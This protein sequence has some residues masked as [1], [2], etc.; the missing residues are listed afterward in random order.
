MGIAF[1]NS[2]D[3][4]QAAALMLK[5]IAFGMGLIVVAWLASR[6][7]FDLFPVHDF[8]KA[9]PSMFLIRVSAVSI[10]HK[11]GVSGGTV[12]RVDAKDS[13]DHR[14][15]ALVHLYP[16][17]HHRLR[18]C[19]QSRSCAMDRTQTVFAAIDGNVRFGFYRHWMLT[20]LWHRWNSTN[21]TVAAYIKGSAAAV[22]AV[23]FLIR[24]W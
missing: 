15:G 1:A 20:L 24:P 8:W 2:R 16:S 4:R 7:P 11:P 23:E 5:S 14:E 3:H 22:F 12:H 17:S 19:L 10:F 21:H 13:A 6:L 9:N 18:V